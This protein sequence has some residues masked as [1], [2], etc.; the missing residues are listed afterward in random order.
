MIKPK[1]RSFYLGSLVKVTSNRNDLSLYLNSLI[2]S[3]FLVYPL[4]KDVKM[5]KF[6]RVSSS[7]IFD[8]YV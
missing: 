7:R 5:M 3:A 4:M 8:I 6:P 2:A 1:S